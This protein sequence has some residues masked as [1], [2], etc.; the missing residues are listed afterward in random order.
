[1]NK[2]GRAA[3]AGLHFRGSWRASRTVAAPTR[4]GDKAHRTASPSS[5]FSAPLLAKG[6]MIEPFEVF[7][8]LEQPAME[9]LVAQ[10]FLEIPG[11]G[12]VES[13]SGDWESGKVRPGMTELVDQCWSRCHMT[14][15]KAAAMRPDSGRA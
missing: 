10:G 6:T 2:P 11:I 4:T 3:N 1:M 12:A 9:I 15:H 7:R 5:T 14:E 13:R 8:T